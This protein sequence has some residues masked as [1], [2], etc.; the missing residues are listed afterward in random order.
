M[1]NALK[2]LIGV[3]SIAGI[4]A[5][6]APTSVTP[7]K[8]PVAATA[9]AAAPVVAAPGTNETADGEAVEEQT[10]NEPEEEEFFKFGEPTIDGKPYTGGDDGPSDS[11]DSDSQNETSETEPQDNSSDE[12]LPP[13]FMPQNAGQ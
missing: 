8:P 2:L 12:P 5:F 9:A 11:D 13:N 10:D 7:P 6:L 3:L 1:D 4:L